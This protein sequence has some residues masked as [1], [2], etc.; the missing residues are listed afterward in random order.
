MAS[1]HLRIKRAGCF[2]KAVP[3]NGKR[4]TSHFLSERCKGGRGQPDLEKCD[5]S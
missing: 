2:A 1:L 4:D 3:R 5:K